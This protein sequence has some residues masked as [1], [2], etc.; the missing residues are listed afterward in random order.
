MNQM[1]LFDGAE[2]L[3]ITKPIRLIELFAG[4]GSQALALKYLGVPFEHHRISEWAIKSIQAYKDMHFPNDDTD[5]S[6]G[7]D[8]KVIEYFLYGK[9]SSDYNAPT[10]KE[11][12]ARMPEGALRRIYNNM[13]STNNLGSILSVRGGDLGITETNK[14]TYILTYS[15][16][17]Q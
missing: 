7:M 17:C 6:N 13:K 15:F 4:Y 14:Y 3:R 16:P 9:V 12:L 1:S 2:K 11:Q 10:A 8:R 5:Y